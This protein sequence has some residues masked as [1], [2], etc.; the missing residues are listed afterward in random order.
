[1]RRRVL[2]ILWLCGTGAHA[3][4]ITAS[5]ADAKLGIAVSALQMPTDFDKELT[6]GL[7]HRIYVRSSLLD[8]AALVQQRAAEITIRYDLWDQQFI[9]ITTMDNT[10]ADSRRLATVADVKAYFSPLRLTNLF[11]TAALPPNRPLTVRSELL[12]NPIEREK[13]SNIRKW[14]AANSTPSMGAEQ[15]D[16]MSSAII[17]HLF[18]QYA[19]GSDL[20]SV[21]R[22]AVTSAPFRLDTLPNDKH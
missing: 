4:E 15:G 2:L 17:N 3:A 9:V 6:S 1:M 12:L 14:V 7:T 19:D 21:W 16:S 20:A 11:A 5:I 18:E 13:L 22:V 8:A 10:V